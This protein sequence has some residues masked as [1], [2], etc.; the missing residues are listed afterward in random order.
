[1]ID[2]SN[3]DNDFNPRTKV[4]L[5]DE[6]GVVLD[7]MRSGFYGMVRW[8]TPK[9]LDNEDWI[10]LFGV[11]TQIGGKIIDQNHQFKYINDDG[12]LKDKI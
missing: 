12:S 2:N 4:F 1:M 8:D 5:D 6:Y 3:I 7:I 9:E 10:G 11:F